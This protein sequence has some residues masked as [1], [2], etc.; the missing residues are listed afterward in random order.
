MVKCRQS[1]DWILYQFNGCLV[2]YH[3][4]ASSKRNAQEL[5]IIKR[6]FKTLKLFENNNSNSYL[7]NVFSISNKVIER[8]HLAQWFIAYLNMIEIVICCFTVN[9]EHAI[10]FWEIMKSRVVLRTLYDGTFSKNSQ[11][12]LNFRWVIIPI[13]VNK[14]FCV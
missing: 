9:F 14:R 4:I 8:S 11:W 6:C 10:N 1:K 13:T 12:L 7:L 3:I 5:R 2:L